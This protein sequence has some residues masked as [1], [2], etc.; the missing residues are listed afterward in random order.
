MKLETIPDPTPGPGE[1]I[2]EVGA[3]GVCYHDVVTRDGTLKAGVR[4]PL[5][6]GHEIAGTVVDVGPGVRTVTVGD[7]VATTQRARICG[8]CRFCRSQREPL[9]DDAEFLGDTR[10]NG[11]YAEYVAV[12]EDNVAKVPQDVLLEWA[13]IAACAIGTM[14]HAIRGVAN[15]QIGE[16]V[17]VTGAGG[18]LGMHGVQLARRSGAFVVAQTTSRNKARQLVEAGAH[19][20][21]VAARGEDFSAEVKDV[22]EGRGV[23]VAVDNVGTP[24]YQFTRRSVAKGGRWV[25]VGQLTGDFVSFNPAQLFLKGLSMLSATSTTREELRDCLDLLRP[26]GI[27]AVVENTAPLEAAS[28]AHLA[29]ESGTTAGRIVLLP[30]QSPEAFQSAS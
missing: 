9:C 15:V 26:G 2:I 17:L 24:L 5:I 19:H 20:V 6:P 16:R 12:G 27:R 21:V 8:H 18:G 22:T 7:R 14:Y 28:K 4:M 30:Q 25:L 3:C 23:D 10:L 29:L 1:V 13:S 11:G